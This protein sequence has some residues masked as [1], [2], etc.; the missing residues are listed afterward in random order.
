MND[1]KNETVRQLNF[2][3]HWNASQLLGPAKHLLIAAERGKGH[4]V[5]NIDEDVKSLNNIF[6]DLGI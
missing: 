4:T 2:V 6:Y 3:L 5:Y 1:P